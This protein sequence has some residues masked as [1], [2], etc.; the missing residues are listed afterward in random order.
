MKLNKY[1]IRKENEN[2]YTLMNLTG[3]TLEINQIGKEILDLIMEGKEKIEILKILSGTYDV[4]I[5]ILE[6]DLDSFLE[7]LKIARIVQE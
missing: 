4:S 2:N 6:N 5:K 3:K 1:V 7:K